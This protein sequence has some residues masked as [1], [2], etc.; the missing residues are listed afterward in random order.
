MLK[1]VVDPRRRVES[2]YDIVRDP[3]ERHDRLRD[4]TP[5]QVSQWRTLILDA[6]AHAREA[7]D[8]R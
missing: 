6:Q 5:Q 4:M 8:R 3:D 1:F 7:D 2:A